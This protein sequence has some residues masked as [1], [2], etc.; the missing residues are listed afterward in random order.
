MEE[1]DSVRDESEDV[2]SFNTKGKGFLY[3]HR[4]DGPAYI[5]KC[6]NKR[7]WYINNTL[8]CWVGDEHTMEDREIMFLAAGGTRFKDPEYD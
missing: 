6:T 3:F 5:Q 8:I 1:C 4:L 2:L 7:S